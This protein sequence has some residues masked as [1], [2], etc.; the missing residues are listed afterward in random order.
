MDENIV[1]TLLAK[2]QTTAKMEFLQSH[3]GNGDCPRRNPPCP[4]WKKLVVVIS[5]M[6]LDWTR[7]SIPAKTVAHEAA[8][9]A[10]VTSAILR[11]HD[12]DIMA[13]EALVLAARKALTI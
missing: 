7:N 8:K 10:R 9:V 12:L 4:D 1:A 5:L 13:G 11:R 3:L 2:T 6:V